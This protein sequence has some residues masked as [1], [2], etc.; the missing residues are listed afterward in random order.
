[1]FRLQREA[2][3]KPGKFFDLV[4]LAQELHSHIN[5]NYPEVNLQIFVE[6]FKDVGK[7]Y[8]VTEYDN[9]DSYAE[10]NTKL[11]ADQEFI[12]LNRKTDGLVVDGSVKDTLMRSL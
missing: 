3:S 11:M 2:L 6:M 12:L 4:Q 1:M 8:W 7:V 10:F 9:L 5:K